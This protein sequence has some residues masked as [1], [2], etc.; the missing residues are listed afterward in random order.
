MRYAGSQSGTHRASN[1]GPVDIFRRSWAYIWGPVRAM[2]GVCR[3][4]EIRRNLHVVQ[5][6]RCEGWQEGV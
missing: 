4:G 3:A 1:A 5:V 6:T 2:C